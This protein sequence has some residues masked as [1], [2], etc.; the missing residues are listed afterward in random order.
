MVLLILVSILGLSEISLA[1]E[2]NT[3]TITKFYGKVRLFKNPS[4]RKVGKGP[5]VKIDGAY[6]TVMKAKKGIKLKPRERLQTG[7]KAKAKLVYANGDQITVSADT[8]YEVVMEGEAGVKKPVY[9]MIFGK[10]RGLIRS[11][12]PRTG[13]KVRSSSMTMG[14][15]G[16]DFYVQ[17]R[18]KSGASEVSVLRGEV[19]VAPRVKNAKPVKVASGFTVQVSAPKPK[20][21]GDKVVQAPAPIKVV[22]TDKKIIAKIFKQTVITKKEEQA[23]EKIEK[24]EAKAKPEPVDP[25]LKAE[26]AQLETAAIEAT[27]KDIK[28]HDPELYKKISKI[29]ADQLNSSDLQEISTKKA[30][31]V[32]PKPKASKA[33]FDD[34]E[35]SDIYDKYFKK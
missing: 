8:A 4:D 9:E 22:P 1:K 11:D 3:A 27:K 12:G 23:Q 17:A 32:A 16:T 29:P 31:D 19:E 2:V 30:F 21:V 33:K 14:V 20:K 35:S 34:L 10:L 28:K 18:G 13:M 15:R 25:K 24:A 5:F 26:L 7:K 6:Y